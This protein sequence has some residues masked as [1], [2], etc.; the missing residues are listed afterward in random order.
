MMLSRSTGIWSI[1]GRAN[2]S[3]PHSAKQGG[4]R[5]GEAFEQAGMGLF[6]RMPSAHK[7]VAPSNQIQ[8]FNRLRL[9]VNQPILAHPV[10]LVAIPFVN[11]IPPPRVRGNDLRDQVRCPH[12]TLSDDIQVVISDEEHV[13]LNGTAWA[14]HHVYRRDPHF[15]QLMSINPR[16]EHFI[17]SGHDFLMKKRRCG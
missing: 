6:L 8:H 2:G 7:L 14:E 15:A 12:D 16:I 10:L 9:R 3:L 5:D 13:R 11:S 17:E 4:D 1:V